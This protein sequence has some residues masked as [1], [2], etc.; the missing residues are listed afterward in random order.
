MKLKIQFARFLPFLFI[1]MVI[2][3]CSSTNRAY[4]DTLKLAMSQEDNEVTL[5][6]VRQTRGDLMAVKHGARVQVI[7]ALAFIE[8]GLQKWVSADNAILSMHHGVI[9]ES[10]GFPYDL[11][12]HSNLSGNP[13]AKPTAGKGEWHYITDVEEY[14]YGLEVNSTWQGGEPA[15]LTIFGNSFAV[16]VIEQHVTFPGALPFYEANLSWV[17]RYWVSVE[18][19]EVLKSEQQVSPVGERL[20]MVYLSRAQRMIDQKGANK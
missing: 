12:F 14:G 5:D 11:V 7:M 15:S 10:Y 8:N 2:T 4:Y 18:T 17:N 1:G 13:L 19:G 20:I 3:G 16:N 9:T 6:Q